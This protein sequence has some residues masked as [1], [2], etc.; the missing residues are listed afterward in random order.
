MPCYLNQALISLFP[1]K[2][3]D[4]TIKYF[5]P[6]SLLCSFAEIIA[7]FLTSRLAINLNQMISKNK[8]VFITGRCIQDNFLLAE[9]SVRVLS[10]CYVQF[11]HD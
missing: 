10:S 11:D 9:Q 1:K 4:V 5:C 7:K 6:I 2:Y 8:S 3:C